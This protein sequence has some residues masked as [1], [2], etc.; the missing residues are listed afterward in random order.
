MRAFL[1]AGLHRCAYAVAAALHH[2]ASRWRAP[3]NLE[4]VGTVAVQRFELRPAN[5]SGVRGSCRAISP[6]SE[7]MA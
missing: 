1:N 7:E 5:Q 6:M 3:S 4:I 2:G